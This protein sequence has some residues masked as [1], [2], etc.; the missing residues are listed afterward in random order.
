MTDKVK[1][2]EEDWK[3]QL[4]AEEFRILRQK[5]TEYA[6]SGEFWDH[7]G[8]G[9]YT[10]A[11]CSF[12]L[13]DSKT[14]FKSGTGWPSFYAPLDGK[15]IKEITDNSYGMSRVEVVCNR[16]DGHLGHVF[17]DG[18]EPTGLSYCI[19]SVSLDFEDKEMKKK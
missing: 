15:R 9:Q 11:A 18:P 12:P 4:T 1:K 17:N 2:S 13:F 8:T 10:C 14:K 6:F 3:K 5:G 7:K 19:N 16:C